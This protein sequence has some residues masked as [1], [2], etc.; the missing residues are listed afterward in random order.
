VDFNRSGNG[1][2]L[3][4]FVRLGAFNFEVRQAWRVKYHQLRTAERYELAA[5]RQQGLRMAKMAEHLGR[6]GPAQ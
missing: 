4:R 3:R 5:M 6:Q 1:G 2:W